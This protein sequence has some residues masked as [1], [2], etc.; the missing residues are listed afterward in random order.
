[1]HRKSPGALSDNAFYVLS[2]GILVLSNK[3]V[4]VKYGAA[5]LML[6]KYEIESLA[7]Q[8]AFTICFVKGGGKGG[9]LTQKLVQAYMY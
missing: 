1:M 2:V 5:R 8:F 9:F 6:V 4:E 3:Y 7:G